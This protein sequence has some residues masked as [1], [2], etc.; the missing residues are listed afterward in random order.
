MLRREL[1]EVN[2][3]LDLLFRFPLGVP[4]VDPTTE[5]GRSTAYS[6]PTF[7]TTLDTVSK[8]SVSTD[9]TKDR[10]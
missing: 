2:L 10:L 8:S 6:S 1:K 9:G 7:I 3:N 4:V 5:N